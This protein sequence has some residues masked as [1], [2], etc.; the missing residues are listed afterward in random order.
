MAKGSREVGEGR[1]G[2]MN[3]VTIGERKWGDTGW[4]RGRGV[5]RAVS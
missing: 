4:G 5:A 2:G 1:G 3:S